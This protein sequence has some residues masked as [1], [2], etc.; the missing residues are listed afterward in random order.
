M[1]SVDPNDPYVR[2][3]HELKSADLMGLR[4]AYLEG[5]AKLAPPARCVVDKSLGNYMQLGLMTAVF[6]K[7]RVIHCRRNAADTCFSCYAEHLSPRQAYTTDLHALGVVHREY[8]RLME[9]WRKT[10]DIPMLEVDYEAVVAD[11]ESLTRRILDF[12]GLPFDEACLRFHT[13]DRVAHTS[14]YAQIRQPIYKTAVSRA[15]RF[16]RH[17]GPLFEALG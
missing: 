1:V 14:S 13:S 9:H 17:L 8:E 2:N 16:K 12:C 10:I 7:P 6:G 4:T 15:E 3:I 5:I 11:P